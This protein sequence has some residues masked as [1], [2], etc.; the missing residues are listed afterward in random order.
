VILLLLVGLVLIGLAAALF[1]KSLLVSRRLGAETMTQIGAY[2][3]EAEQVA[4]PK[5]DGDARGVDLRGGVDALA[6]RL[7]GALSGRVKSV[8]EENLKAY[9]YAAG[10]YTTPPRR[11]VG[12]QVLAS[13]TLGAFWLWFAV[14]GDVKPF[15]VIV[16]LVAA[17]AGGWVLPLY[18]VKRRG[19]LRAERIDYAMPELIDSLVTTVEAGLS[20]NA[21]LQIAARRF[22]GPLG[23]EMRLTLQ[24]QSMGLNLNNALENLLMRC[25]TTSVRSFVR[26]MLQGEQLGVSIGQTLRNLASEMRNRRRQMAEERAHKAPVKIIFPLILFIFPATMLVMMGPAFIHVYQIF[27]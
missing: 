19:R 27:H 17:V 9:L 23:E 26:A 22:R 2:G 25:N 20:F 3:F 21:S 4:V 16:G 14:A 18:Y 6:S 24:E 1:A 13:V 8:S 12:Y 5:T 15:L 7:G 11:F 10:F